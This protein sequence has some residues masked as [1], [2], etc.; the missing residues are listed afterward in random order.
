VERHDA[1]EARAAMKAHLQ[2]VR[3]DSHAS[4]GKRMPLRQKNN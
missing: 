1:S 3:D 4:S 2:Q